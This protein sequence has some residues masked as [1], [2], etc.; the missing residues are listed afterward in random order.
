MEAD[1]S[2]KPLPIEVVVLLDSGKLIDAIKAL[3]ATR[4]MSLTQAKAWVDWHMKQN[5]AKYTQLADEQRE[6]RR[7]IFYWVLV[8]DA[9]IIAGILYWFYFRGTP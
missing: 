6:L 4:D 9:F 1:T 8:V 2:F 7:R 3:R 5:P